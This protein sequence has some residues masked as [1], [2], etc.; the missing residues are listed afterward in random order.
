MGLVIGFS[1]LMLILRIVVPLILTVLCGR[2]L[3]CIEERWAEAY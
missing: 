1:I 2:A 3:C